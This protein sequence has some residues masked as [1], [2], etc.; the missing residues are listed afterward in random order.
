MFHKTMS[1]AKLKEWLKIPIFKNVQGLFCLQ[2]ATSSSH[3]ITRL[4]HFKKVYPSSSLTRIQ[5]YDVIPLISQATECL[6][7]YCKSLFKPIKAN[8]TQM[9]PQTEVT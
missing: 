9:E 2:M 3:V 8:L 1:D 7:K 6:D 5:L 4:S